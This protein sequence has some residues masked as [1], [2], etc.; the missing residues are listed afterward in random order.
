MWKQLTHPNIVPVLGV[1]THPFQLVSN[2]MP[3][4]DLPDH[5]GRNPDV[6]RPGLV[7]IPAVAFIL[8]LPLPQ[9]VRRR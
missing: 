9:A 7:G 8:H 5:I 3:H 1:T 4:G 6:D 2:W